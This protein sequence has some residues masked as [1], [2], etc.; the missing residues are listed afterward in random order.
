MMFRKISLLALAIC[1]LLIVL[2]PGLAQAQQGGLTVLNTSVEAGFPTRLSFGLSARSDVNINDIRLH[3]AVDRISFAEVI[4]EVYIEFAPATEIE[5]EW[6]WDMRKT[7]G[8]PPGSS[9]SYW[10]TL[11][12]ASGNTLETRPTQVPFDD[13]RY[14][15]Q[16]LTEGMV[17]IHWYQGK[18]SFAR[19][20]MATT[21]QALER[22]TDDTGAYLE[23]PVNL[24]IYD[25]SGDL[26]GAM[27]YPQEWTGGVAFTQYGTI[28]I[29]IAQNNLDWG[30]RAIAHELTHQVI[31]QMTL[32]P[33]G[34]LPTWLNEGLAMHTE[35]LPL[36]LYTTF[37]S[38]AVA[39]D[40]LISVR[41]LSSHFSAHPDEAGL[42]YAQSQSLVAF[43]ISSY[44]RD[45]ML[46]L[47][48]IFKQ[49]SGYDAA[50]ERVY[51][52]DMD[53]LDTLW[54][55][56]VNKQF[57]SLKDKKTTTALTSLPAEPA[58]EPLL[59]L[60]VAG[61]SQMRRLF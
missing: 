38:Q 39:E 9:V 51:G 17:T 27:I 45:K 35:G 33:Y 23:R 10:W 14:S 48:N 18:E 54:R 6:A 46:E 53:G 3:Y 20:L 59:V 49:G 2:S 19:E 55:D 15:W 12:D 22:L 24:Y 26:Q 5:V 52:F 13:V 41:S 1:L 57:Q 42:S 43:L 58:M 16:S 30:K 40:S 7:G 56:Y 28:A 32:N 44:G 8:L 34:G 47:L 11:K 29:G 21:Q 25:G 60:G 37:L 36:P 31:H 4:S 50:L 61:T